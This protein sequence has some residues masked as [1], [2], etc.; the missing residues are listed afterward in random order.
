MSIDAPERPA[1]A[2]DRP[3]GAPAR[4]RPNLRRGLRG[5]RR[6]IPALV[7]AALLFLV[8][9]LPVLFIILAAFTT[10]VPRP[11]GAGLGGF[12]LEN[13]EILGTSQAVESLLNSLGVGV[14]AAVLSL[15]IGASLAFIAARTDAPWRR[16]VYVAGIAPMFLPAI[17]GALAW[18]ILASPISGHLNMALREVGIG[19]TLDAYSYGGLIFVLG[20][21]YA[22]YTFMLTYSSFAMMNADLEEA[23]AVHGAGLGSMFRTVTLP[24]AIPAL[25]GAAI[26]SFVLAVENFPV[27]AILGNPGDIETLP[28]Y[29]YRLMAGNPRPNAAAA[30]AIAL[31]LAVA[32]V[33]WGQQRIVARKRFTT[34]TGKGNR[35]RPVPLRGLRWVA[36][37]FAVLYFLLAVVLPVGALLVTATSGAPYANTFADLF[38]RGF[39]LDRFAQAISQSDFR[40]STTN[41]VTLALLAAVVGT[42]L[43]FAVSYV[44]YRS[45]TRFGPFLEQTSMMPLAIPQV[46]LG[47]GILWAWLSLPFP[48]YGTLAILVIATVAVNMPQGYRSVSS[49]MLQLDPDLENSAVMLGASR[50]RAVRNVT[51]PLMRTGIVSTLLMLLMLGLREMSAVLFLYTSDTRV[52]S[53]L[54]FHSFE[55]GSISYSAAISLI[56][57]LII[58][59]LAIATQVVGARERRAR[60]GS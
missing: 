9:I 57:T 15:L 44:R 20:L 33:T 40:T 34:L 41:S 60:D 52:L 45:R 7:L 49:S 18:S 25:A 37:G 47:M 22:P 3:A 24:L 8:V 10:R 42:A 14:G 1:P 55:N 48:V 17:V 43:A 6:E 16:F 59:A 4:R 30:I 2:A 46:V 38:S 13:F 29:I 56:F 39:S 53:I 23:A 31:T 50:W 11:G 27:N 12:T 28:T 19:L 51:A 54:V 58:A 21:Y 5:V 26:L 32:L 36:T 35:P